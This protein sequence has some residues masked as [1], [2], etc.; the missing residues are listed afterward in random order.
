MGAIG[1]Y[2][3]AM[4]Q[5]RAY[6][7]YWFAGLAAV[8]ERYQ[9]LASKGTIP[10]DATLDRLL[11]DEHLALLGGSVPGGPGNRFPLGSPGLCGSSGILNGSGS[12]CR[13]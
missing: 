3:A 10:A 5:F 12:A 4:T 9:E 1:D 2:D 11:D 13:E 6:V 7:A 8:V